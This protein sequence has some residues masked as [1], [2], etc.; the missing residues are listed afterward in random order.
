MTLAP[1]ITA[2]GITAP[3]YE[4]IYAALQDAYRSIYGQDAYLA[5]DSQDGQWIGIQAAAIN[6]CNAAA[7]AIYNAYSPAT[8]QGTALSNQ[9][10]LNGLRRKIATNSEATVL[11]VGTV[12]TVIGA[13]LIA[14][15]N[16]QQWSL[17]P[18][19]VIPTAGQILV[20]ATAVQPGNLVAPAG[21]ITRI[22]TP[23]L[24]WQTV[25]NPTAATPGDPVETDATLRSRQSTSTAGPST[26]LLEGI[27]GAVAALSGIKDFR[28]Y[29]NDTG[30]ADANGIPGHSICLVCE[31]GDPVEIA[32]VIARRKTPGTGTYGTTTEVIVDSTGVP[33]TINFLRPTV[34]R[35]TLRLALQLHPGY[36]STTQDAIVAALADYVS[37]LPI[38]SPVYLNKLIGLAD[39]IDPTYNVVSIVDA[40]FP[41]AMLPADL[42]FA[43]NERP[44]LDVADIT[45]VTS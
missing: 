38:G 4:E 39:S 11:L 41:N 23:T 32:T 12:G 28:F 3:T 43:F 16:G 44:S 25:T 36:L 20:N 10:K 29:E 17:P 2:T 40:R 26:S 21:T 31:G 6:D 5:P 7:I 15:A 19:V 37:S 30:A 22:M 14:D 1:T 8:A 18:N 33:V 24:G 45:V 34:V 35:L 13:G 27:A 42:L 9:V